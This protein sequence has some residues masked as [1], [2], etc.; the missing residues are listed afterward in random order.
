[1][2]FAASKLVDVYFDTDDLRLTATDGAGAFSCTVKV[3]AAA[4]P[5]HHWFTA[6]ER[7]SGTAAQK[8]FWVRT[9]WPQFH[10]YRTSR[11][12]FNRYENTLNASNAAGLDVL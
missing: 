12:G 4:Q 2:G 8:T 11:T 9:D 1:M 7:I 3:P 10:G 5:L 6:A